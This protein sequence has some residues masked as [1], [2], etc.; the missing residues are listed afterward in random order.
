MTV[1]SKTIKK[2][3]KKE[4]AKAK[5]EAVLTAGKE[6]AAK[7]AGMTPTEKAVETIA[8]RKKL[9]AEAPDPSTTGFAKVSQAPNTAAQTTELRRQ[10]ANRAAGRG[11]FSDTAEDLQELRRILHQNR[12]DPEAIRITEDILGGEFGKPVISGQAPQ[13]EEQMQPPL[14]TEAPPLTDG[15]L[16]AELNQEF[17]REEIRART[18]TAALGIAGGGPLISGIKSLISKATA[19]GTAYIATKGLSNGAVKD[20]AAGKAFGLTETL[21]SARGFARVNT[22]TAS[23]ITEYLTAAAAAAS[24]PKVSTPVILGIIGGSIGTYPWASWSEKEGLDGLN[25]AL[26]QALDIGDLELYDEISEVYDAAANPDI[27]DFI[28]DATPIVNIM[29]ANKLKKAGAD[30]SKKARDAKREQIR[31]QIRQKKL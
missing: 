22:S 30:A 2:R 23:K 5:E 7:R 8:K 31:E 10:E 29:K 26:K 3:K 4:K 20:A 16:W 19:K 25:F 18:G 28:W 9:R 24:N 15:G 1:E 12:N 17:T 13:E 11:S 27:W 6:L 21:L 14:Q